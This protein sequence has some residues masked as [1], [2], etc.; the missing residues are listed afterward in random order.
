[1]TRLGAAVLATAAAA[2]TARADTPTDAPTATD[3][4]RWTAS[5]TS[6]WAG[7][8]DPR[9]VG[10][11]HLAFGLTASGITQ[12]IRLTS[13]TGEDLGAP[14]SRRLALLA[15]AAYGVTDSVEIDASF[16]IYLQDGDRLEAVGDPRGLRAVTRGDLRLGGKFQVVDR[17]VLRAG[18]AADVVL[19]TGDDLHYAGEASWVLHWRALAALELGPIGIAFA[20][21]VRIRGEEVL[22]AAGQVAGNEVVGGVALAYRLPPISGVICDWT[23]LRLIA[24]VDGVVGDTVGEVRGPS[25]FEARVGIRG[26]IWRGW[27]IG[28]VGGRG[29]TDEVG[30]PRWRGVLEVSWRDEPRSDV[31]RARAAEEIVVDDCEGED[32]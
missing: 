1:V 27:T 12:P 11:G 7:L 23:Q 21:G 2:A 32:C 6:W 22:L 31:P 5:A 15:S 26:R 28:V 9:V 3:V 14:V 8:E 17:A 16:P 25:P 18:F 19:P 20:A 29:L 24:E 30:A 13:A 4:E 10:L